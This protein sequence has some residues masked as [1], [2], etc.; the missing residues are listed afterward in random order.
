MKK[1]FDKLFIASVIDGILLGGS[2]MTALF[3]H[4]N[5]AIALGVPGIAMLQFLLVDIKSE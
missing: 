4:V 5:Y 1:L 3:G 2:V